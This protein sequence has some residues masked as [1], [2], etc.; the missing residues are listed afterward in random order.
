MCHNFFRKWYPYARTWGRGSKLKTYV[1]VQGERG[2]TITKFERTCSMDDRFPFVHIL[3]FFVIFWFM[4]LISNLFQLP[5]QMPALFPQF[6]PCRFNTTYSF[7]QSVLIC[8]IP[9]LLSLKMFL[10]ISLV[11]ELFSFST[12]WQIPN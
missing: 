5:F 2:S 7:L 12:L 4:V 8:F 6:L 11:L 3:H 10:L 9:Y 1:H